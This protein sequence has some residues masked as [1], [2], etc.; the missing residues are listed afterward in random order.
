MQVLTETY[1]NTLMSPSCS[2]ANDNGDGRK[3]LRPYFIYMSEEAKNA[4]ESSQ[5][6]RVH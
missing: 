6:F 1:N 3:V 5:V 2:G 4:R